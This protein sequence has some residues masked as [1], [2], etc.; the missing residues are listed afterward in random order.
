MD[1]LASEVHVWTA[2]LGVSRSTLSEFAST[3]APAELERAARFHFER[4]RHRFIAGR[5]LLR[6]LLGRY[7]Q[8]DPR[9]LEFTY[10]PHGKPAVGGVFAGTGLEFN[11]AHCE[12]L[13]LIA[14]TRT[15]A[16]GVDLERVRKLD[17]AEAL[18][19]RFFSPRESAAFRALPED[20]KPMAF[21]NLWTRKEAWLKATG[22]GIAHSLH[23]V[24]VS[25]LPGEPARLLRLPKDLQSGEPWE[26]HDLA[27]AQGFAGALAVAATNIRVRNR[28]WASDR[29]ARQ[30]EELT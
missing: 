1:D 24:E 19:D 4:D 3:L 13:A 6:A 2:S 20:Q 9:A 25:F 16:L 7:L 12:E 8:E 18:V 28:R 27:P 5:G 22:E 30:V 17:E 15:G 11:L 23:R 10:A 21:F 26:L 14:I 29:K